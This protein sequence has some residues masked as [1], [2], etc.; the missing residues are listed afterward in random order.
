[1]VVLL[2]IIYVVLL[3]YAAKAFSREEGYYSTITIFGVGCF[4]YYISIPLEMSLLG[5]TEH[6]KDA[7]VIKLTQTQAV[8]IVAMGLMAFCSFTFG[9]RLSSFS[10]FICQIQFDPGSKAF[11]VYSIAIIVVA[12]VFIEVLFYYDNIKMSGSYISSSLLHYNEPVFTLLANLIV[13]FSSVAGAALMSEKNFKNKILGVVLVLAI[14]SW[15]IYSSDKNVI[16]IGALACASRLFNISRKQGIGAL[17]VIFG[18]IILVVY[19]VKFFS[20]YRGGHSISSALTMALTQFGARFID[21]LGPFVSLSNAINSVESYQCGKTYMEIL[22]L[23][24]PRFIWNAR[25]PD[26]SEQ[27]AMDNIHNWVPS[28][29]M[30]FSPLAESYINFSFIGPFIQYFILGLTWGLFWKWLRRILWYYPSHYWNSMYYVIGFYFLI[31]VHRGPISSLLKPLFHTFTVLFLL[32]FCIDLLIIGL[33]RRGIL[34][35]FIFMT[36]RSNDI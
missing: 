34:Q 26:I 29:G 15:G 21:P 10:P 20:L 28:E 36:K 18:G 4:L 2:S 25:P 19:L 33:R 13:L 32:V 17:L 3:I 1:M 14:V 12:S 35:S 31:L 27:F 5:I 6:I 16:L 23:I 7:F 11:C 9:Y 22:Y 8:A 30:G 24:V